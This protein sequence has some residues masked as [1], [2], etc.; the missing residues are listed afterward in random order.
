MRS[1]RKGIFATNIIKKRIE[2][3]SKRMRGDDE[4][5]IAH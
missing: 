1:Y 4:T 5:L 2:I 3:M